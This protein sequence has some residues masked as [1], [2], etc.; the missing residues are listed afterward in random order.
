MLKKYV[1]HTAGFTL[2]EILI[3]VA[4]IV[5]LGSSALFSSFA[6]RDQLAFRNGY[7]M[8]EG[9]VSEARNLALSGDAFPDMNDYDNDE[10]IGDADLILPNG[11]IM[12]VTDDGVNITMYLYADLFGSVVGELDDDDQFIKIIELPENVR[13]TVDARTKSGDEVGGFPRDNITV[14][15]TT[16]DATFSVL[17]DGILGASTTS[18]QLKLEQTEEDDE[19]NVLRKKHLFLH[20]LHGIPELLSESYF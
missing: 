12:Q 8:L 16:P 11:Y 9:G 20:Y 7:N 6:M 14:M 19:D 4:I 3:V 15:Y 10:L 5:F 17:D 1:F 13:L 18:V 2:V